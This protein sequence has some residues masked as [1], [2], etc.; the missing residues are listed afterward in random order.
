VTPRHLFV[1]GSLKRGSTVVERSLLDVGARF[2]SEGSTT[3]ELYDLGD[4]PG[5]V[6]GE[7]GRVQGEI[8][9]MA[10]PDRLLK[11]LDRY[12][13]ARPDGSGEYARKILRATLV[14]GGATQDCWAYV[15]QRPLDNTARI[16]SGVWKP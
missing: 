16:R 4:Y 11:A 12:E 2:V 14:G 8:Y 1:Y 5:L 9:E 7:N 13:D 15:Y 6:P 10:D 3:G